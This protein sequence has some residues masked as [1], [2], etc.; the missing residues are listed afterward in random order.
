MELRQRLALKPRV[1][2]RVALMV[3]L[4]KGT[5]L[6]SGPDSFPL[7]FGGCPTNMAFPKKGSLFSRVTEQLR[8]TFPF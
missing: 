8:E 6:F 2:A 3:S 4:R 1:V 5:Q 7:F